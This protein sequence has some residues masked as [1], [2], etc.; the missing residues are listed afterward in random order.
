MLLTLETVALLR[1]RLL[2]GSQGLQVDLCS[3]LQL[4]KRDA[5]SWRCPAQHLPMLL[6]LL[7]LLGSMRT[8]PLRLL[9]VC[10][11]LLQNAAALV[12]TLLAQQAQIPLGVLFLLS[13]LLKLGLQA[14]PPSFGRLNRTLKQCFFALNDVGL[15]M[16]AQHPQLS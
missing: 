13:F 11:Q 15:D 12:V 4:N 14:G 16:K 9:Q 1:Q 8:L 5:C 7:A 6:Y 10:L 3:L 2:F